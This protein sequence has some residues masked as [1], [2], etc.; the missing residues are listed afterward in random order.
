MPAHTS[1]SCCS[2]ATTSH[3]KSPIYYLGRTIFLPS[4][5]IISPEISLKTGKI[6]Y[7]WNVNLE[8]G[9][10]RTK[11]DPTKAID[12]TW[13][14]RSMNGKWVT[15]FKLPLVGTT[16]KALAADIRIRRQF[17]F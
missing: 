9:S 14:D 4:S 2:V 12:V 17:S 8:S 11:V 7:Q 10:I 16:L 13:V 1:V 5:H 15:D 3:A 6:V